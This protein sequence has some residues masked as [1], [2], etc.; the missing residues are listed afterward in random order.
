MCLLWNL[1]TVGWNLQSICGQCLW[2]LAD[3]LL[4]CLPSPVSGLIWFFSTAAW[5]KAEFFSAAEQWLGSLSFPV[6]CSVAACEPAWFWL[7]VLS[8]PVVDQFWEAGRASAA[9]DWVA[10]SCSTFKLVWKGL[11][12]KL[13]HLNLL[14]FLMVLLLNENKVL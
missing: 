9:A 4:V 11:K 6:A 2:W 5:F 13:K 12:Q 10:S 8:L 1:L 3:I 14:Y 7:V